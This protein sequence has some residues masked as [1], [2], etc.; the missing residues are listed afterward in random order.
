MAKP[1]RGDVILVR[2]PFSDLRATKLRPAV[3]LA[4]HGED[5]VVVGV[6]SGIPASLKQTWLLLEAHHPHFAQ[7]GLKR[8]SI[9]KGEKLAVVHQSVIHSTIGSL[10]PELL[11]EVCRRVKAALQLP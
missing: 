9:L 7:S 3:V 6:F 5:V 2:F 10:H 11:D 1:G 4:A 8:R